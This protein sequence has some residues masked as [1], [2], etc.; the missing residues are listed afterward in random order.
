MPE[1]ITTIG[2]YAFKGCTN[3]FLKDNTIPNNILTIQNE[4]F[5]NCKNI[6][7]T[8]I[9]NNLTTIGKNSF[10]E[11]IKLNISNLPDSLNSIGESAFEGC[12]NYKGS[13]LLK[14]TII[15]NNVTT[16]GKNCF[17]NTG[18]EKLII[19]ENNNLLTNIPND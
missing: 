10:K 17:K 4:A 3:M 2:I 13:Y 9:S 8:S 6:V 14:E 7:I 18:I 15:P 12:I 16:I 11:C 5:E 1:G 19:P